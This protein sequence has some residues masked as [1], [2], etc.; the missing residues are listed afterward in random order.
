MLVRY[1]DFVCKLWNEN[2]QFIWYQSVLIG[3]TFYL[4]DFV[5][6]VVQYFLRK[7]AILEY[8]FPKRSKKFLK[9]LMSKYSLFEKIFLYRIACDSNRKGIFI[10]ITIIN[11]WLNCL[12]FLCSTIG[13]FG[14][15][16]TNGKGWSLTLL[17][18]PEISIL[19][20]TVVIEFIPHLIWLPSERRRYK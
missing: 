2:V 17:L 3:L 7:N 15:V 14:T 5:I 9:K 1:F 8:C 20:I 19:V 13:L 4:F 18:I 11:Q 10:Y 16:I 6:F 12:S